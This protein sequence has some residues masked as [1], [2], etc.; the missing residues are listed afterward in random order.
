MTGKREAMRDGD[1]RPFKQ[2]PPPPLAFL[3][4]KGEPFRWLPR[5]GQPYCVAEWLSQWIVR[6]T[7]GLT[8]LIVAL[9]LALQVWVLA[10]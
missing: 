7:P 10:H 5:H 6:R 8:L 3:P 1:D 9:S 4:L 2:D